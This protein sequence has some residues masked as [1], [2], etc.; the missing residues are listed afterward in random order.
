L[1]SALSTL[2]GAGFGH[3]VFDTPATGILQEAPLL[4]ADFII[5]PFRCEAYSVESTFASMEMV[6]QIAPTTPH[7]LLPVAV[8]RRLRVHRAN[9]VVTQEAMADLYGDEIDIQHGIPNRVAVMEAQSNGQTVWEYKAPGLAD[10]Q[11]EYCRVIGAIR[12]QGGEE[13]SDAQIFE[14][15]TGLKER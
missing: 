11:R 10:V 13:V 14:Q 12:R 6:Q 2:E 3:V 5:V 7:Y 15:I 8:D 1:T 4:V 9:L